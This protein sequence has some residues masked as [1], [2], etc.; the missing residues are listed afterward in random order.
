MSEKA[1]NSSSARG[2]SADS[3]G[4]IPARGWLDILKRTFVQFSKARILLVA[5]GVT[6]YLLL[7]MVP[8]LAVFLSLYGLFFAAEDVG[9]HIQLLAGIMPEG[10]LELIRGEAT[11]IVE[12]GGGALSATLIIGLLIS[13]W[14]A[15]AGMKA[16]IEGLNVAYGEREKRSFLYLNL[17]SLALTLGAMA[18]LLVIIAG[19]A[20]VPLVLAAVAPGPAVAAL[21]TI[22]RWPLLLAMV[23]TGMALLYRFGPSRD[24]PEWRW[25][26][27]GSAVAAI[28]WLVG[29]MLFSWYVANFGEYNA[30]YGSLG[31]VIA[32]LTWLWLSTT[33]VLLGAQLNAEIEH[34]TGRDTTVGPDR[35]M[36][37]RGAR[38]ADTLG[39]ARP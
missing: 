37:A 8:A 19:L 36:G 5:A 32:L 29:S 26:S 28:V 33:V 31:A 10:T 18:A 34:Q 1:S 38:V 22:G 27:W 25:I 11:R 13:L 35:P 17:Q 14:S 12:Q 2:R 9:Q 39:E 23:I 20:I 24:M 30:T 4:E 15:N 21:V 3:P 7:A 6:F 16:I